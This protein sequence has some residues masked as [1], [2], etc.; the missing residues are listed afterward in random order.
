MPVYTF[1]ISVLSTSLL[2]IRQQ[3]TDGF[4]FLS[5]WFTSLHGSIIHFHDL[6]QNKAKN[7]GYFVHVDVV[8]VSWLVGQP[9]ILAQSE[10]SQELL[11]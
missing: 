6:F 1:I 8:T 7:K 2:N 10:I 5:C 11:D 4:F 3:L 9:S